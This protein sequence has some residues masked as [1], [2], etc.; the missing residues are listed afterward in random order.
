VKIKRELAYPLAIGS[1]VP[2][3]GRIKECADL[4]GPGRR[5]LDVGCSSGWLATIVMNK[6]YRSYVG[7]DRTIL[8][9][10]QTNMQA[11]FV[12]GSVFALPFES[13]SFDSACLF[14]VV[15]HLPRGTE[16][17][18]LREVHRVLANGGRLYFSAPHA[19]VI[20]TPLDPVWILGHRHY[21]RSTISTLLQSVGFKLEV[22]FVAGGVAECAD[23]IRLLVNKH[24]LHRPHSPIES[25]NRLIDASHGR[26]RRLGMTVFVTASR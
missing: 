1:P 21:R 8:G 26:N 24:I 14:D 22:M 10:I 4:I 12:E 19:S 3:I 7:V 2:I 25:V 9:P 20:H 16:E 18:A 6:G 13:G 23:H 15:E 5:L 17:L 11:N